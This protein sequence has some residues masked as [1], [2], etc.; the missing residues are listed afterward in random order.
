MIRL[1]KEKGLYIYDRVKQTL[2]IKLSSLK[3][4]TL[5]V[6]GISIFEDRV[7]KLDRKI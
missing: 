5:K 7:F 3:T 4:L 2:V 1:S 6:K